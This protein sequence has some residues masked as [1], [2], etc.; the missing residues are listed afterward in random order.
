MLGDVQAIAPLTDLLQMGLQG[1][2]LGPEQPDFSQPY[3]AILEA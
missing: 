2:Q 1:E 3:D